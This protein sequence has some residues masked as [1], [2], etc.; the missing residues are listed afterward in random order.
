M[1]GREWVSWRLGLA[2]RPGRVGRG[3]PDLDTEGEEELAQVEVDV[4]DT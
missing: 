4:A 1:L 3:R 2:P